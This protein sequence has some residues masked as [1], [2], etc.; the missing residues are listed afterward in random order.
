MGGVS[1]KPGLLLMCH[2]DFPDGFLD[3]AENFGIYK[4]CLS[5]MDRLRD[6]LYYGNSPARSDELSLMGMHLAS[7]LSRSIKLNHVELSY[8]SFKSPGIRQ[9][10]YRAASNGSHTIVCMGAAGLM[11]PDQGASQ[12]IQSELKKVIWDNPAL[13]LIYVPSGIA[14]SD[15]SAMIR[16]SVWHAFNGASGQIDQPGRQHERESTGVVL[17][18]VADDAVRLSA[19][20]SAAGKFAIAASLLSERSRA[21]YEMG[22]SSNAV[23]FMHDVA[24]DIKGHGFHA[25]E[26]GFIDF[27]QPTMEEA[28]QKLL[29]SGASHIIAVALPSLL[30]KHPFSLIGPS[31]AIDRLKQQMPQADL[32][33]VKPDPYPIADSISRLLIDQVMGAE[34]NGT[35]MKDTLRKKR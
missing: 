28:A 21:F 5:A 9:A 20:T 26:A 22:G 29:D 17:V 19:D 6:N 10:I 32:I 11:V 1:N 35:S 3:H 12:F 13:D 15:A 34:L 33:Y 30:H 31:I 8:L 25:V 7:S 16:R 24:S 14:A 27:A 18:C 23:D 4:K 2:G